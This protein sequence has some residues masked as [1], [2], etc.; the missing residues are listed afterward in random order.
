MNGITSSVA[1]GGSSQ[2][3][4][5][6]RR[7]NAMSGA[8]IIIGIS[9]LARPVATGISAAKIMISACT[10]ISWL[11]NSGCINCIPGWNSSAR[12][13]RIIAPPTR[14]MMQRENHVHRADILVVGGKQ[15]APDTVGWPV[16][17]L[18]VCGRL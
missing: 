8:P 3:L 15:P 2:K 1:A 14:N 11:K 12:T 5:L 7:G 17:V 4:Q 10:P 9:Q 16:V 18:V 6:F 13:P